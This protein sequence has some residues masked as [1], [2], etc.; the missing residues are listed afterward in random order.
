V[1]ILLVINWCLFFFSSHNKPLNFFNIYWWGKIRFED[2]ESFTEDGIKFV[3]GDKPKETP[4]PVGA[5]PTRLG[6][7]RGDY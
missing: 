3:E 1:L 2:A 7:G 6:T 4:G 5:F